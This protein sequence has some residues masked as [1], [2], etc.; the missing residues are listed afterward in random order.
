[1]GGRVRFRPVAR[2]RL[3]RR[4]LKEVRLPQ[5]DIPLALLTLNLGVEAAQ[6]L[7]VAI[8]FV[9]WRTIKA[10]IDVPLTPARIAAAYFIGTVAI[11]WLVSRLADFAA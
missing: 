1:M 5:S 7:F 11:L 10:L 2:L 3:C 6:F 4:A 9:A 8:V